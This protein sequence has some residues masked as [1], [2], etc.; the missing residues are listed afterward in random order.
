MSE[1]QE[2]GKSW[3]TKYRPRTM[4]EYSGPTIKNIVQKRFTKKSNMPHVIMI[5]GNRGCGKTTF[6]MIISK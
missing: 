6:A 4:E 2:V 3:Y 1:E 5:Q